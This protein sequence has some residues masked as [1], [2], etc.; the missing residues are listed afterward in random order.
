MGKSETCRVVGGLQRGQLSSDLA[1]SQLQGSFPI[2]H[3]CWR[4]SL[5]QKVRPHPQRVTWA[6]Q[7]PSLCHLRTGQ[8]DWELPEP[9]SGPQARAA[10]RCEED[11]LWG[12]VSPSLVRKPIWEERVERLDNPHH[13]RPCCSKTSAPSLRHSYLNSFQSSHTVCSFLGSL[14]PL[15]NLS[16]EGRSSA[17]WPQ[18]PAWLLEDCLDDSPAA[19]VGLVPGPSWHLCGGG[20]C[21]CSFGRLL[22]Y[23]FDLGEFSLIFNL[24]FAYWS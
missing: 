10:A 16:G 17:G 5:V 7:Q 1:V 24:I 3:S 9:G 14:V 15:P 4:A 18:S 6:L 2:A 8:R 23:L 12:C 22:C 11:Q 13:N 19:F 20:R 21:L